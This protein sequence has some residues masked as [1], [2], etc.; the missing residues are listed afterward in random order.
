MQLDLLKILRCPQSGSELVLHDARVVGDRVESGELATADGQRRYRIAGFI[1]RFVPD[2]NYA[3]N[4]GRQ[5]NHFRRTQLDSHTGLPISRDQF[6]G[7]SAWTRN[8]LA[9]KL[10]LDVGCGAGRFTE[11]ALEAGAHV[12]ALDYSNA[13]DACWLNHQGH[14]RLNVVQGDVYHLP[15]EPG[16]FDY[17]YC[18]GVLQHTPDVHTAFSALPR[19]L[20]PGGKLAVGIYAQ[21]WLNALWPKYWLRPLTKRI[22]QDTLFRLVERA[23]PSMLAASRALSRVPRAGRYLRWL[24]PVANHELDWPLSPQQVHE[25]A[26]LNTFDMLAPHYDQPQRASV[27]RAWFEEAQLSNV[28]IDRVGFLV[29]R[30]RRQAGNGAS[31][32]PRRTAPSRPSP[33]ISPPA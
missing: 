18:Y 12:V 31:V 21:L 20:R 7:Y 15:F 33:P 25:W 8:E 6:Y 26:V 9:G 11:I 5:W 17:V 30:G 2:A 28:E 32:T 19:Q 29:G 14:P 16:Q 4:F 13:V 3:S 27:L 24:V 10:V 1:P 22:P 23:T